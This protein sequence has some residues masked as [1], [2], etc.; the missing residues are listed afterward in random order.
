LSAVDEIACGP[1]LPA[2]DLRFVTVAN[3]EACWRCLM[4]HT[5]TD[6]TDETASWVY[7]AARP[8]RCGTG[9]CGDVVNVDPFHLNPTAAD[10]VAGQLGIADFRVFGRPL[11]VPDNLP[12][13][14]EVEMVQ[15]SQEPIDVVAS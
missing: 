14:S 12:A 5:M 11:V 4:A 15:S 10:E 7:R 8:P 2:G 3:P 1:S 13:G 6:A 9:R